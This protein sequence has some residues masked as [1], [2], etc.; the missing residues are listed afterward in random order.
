M[1]CRLITSQPIIQIK[2]EMKFV[3]LLVITTLSLSSCFQG[4][5]STDMEYETDSSTLLRGDTVV[6]GTQLPALTDT[7]L[8]DFTVID[9]EQKRIKINTGKTNPDDLLFFAKSLI[10]VP[11]LYA[12]SDPSVG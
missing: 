6:P 2:F 3:Y 12:S 11:Y 5:E 8:K 7:N 1:S 4:E 9:K 10:G